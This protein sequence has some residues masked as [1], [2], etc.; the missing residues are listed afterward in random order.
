V[1][2]VRVVHV[3]DSLAASGGAE[4]RLVEEVEAI[5]DRF[6]QRVVRLYARDE[7]QPRL[8]RAGIPVVSLGMSGRHAGRTWP[9]AV[10]RL[11]REL[12]DWRPDVIHTTLFSA[13]LAGQLA[14]CTLRIPVVSSFNRTGDI[15]LQRTLQPGVA[16]WRGRSMHAIAG[17]AARC[18]DVHF[19]A[20]SAYA[21][22]SNCALFDVP[23]ER[24]TV[25]PRGISIEDAPT[26]LSR[27]AFG[28]AD[29][30]PLFVNVARLVPEK[31]QH[32]LVDAF[33]EVRAALPKAELAI[34]GASGSAEPTVRA[35]IA[36]HGLDGA[37]HLLGWRDDVRSLVAAADVFVFSSL[38]EGS[39]SAVLEAMAI[40][41]PVVAFAIAPVVE[42]TGG[43]ARLATT[44]SSDELAEEM[45]AAYAAPERAEEIAAARAWADRFALTDVAQQLGDLLE[46]RAGR[47]AEPARAA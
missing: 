9:L 7:L 6:D 34:A 2:R 20:V 19:R 37:V 30:V 17:R 12:R 5:V 41:T 46:W 25:V 26:H 1:T 29:D 43:H 32:L 45:L 39:P 11:R 27:S 22:D 8:E 14:A 18:G 4:Q 13:N 23:P 33:A 42:L 47:R 31:A 10:W 15:T 40:G 21:R 44:G 35:A 16:G 3:V 28:L 38:S 24:V 36:R